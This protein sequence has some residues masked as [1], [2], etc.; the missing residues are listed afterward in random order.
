MLKR[1]TIAFVVVNA[2]A[3]LSR[4]HWDKRKLFGGS[5][6]DEPSGERPQ[7]TFYEVLPYQYGLLRSYIEQFSSRSEAYYFLPPCFRSQSVEN[8]AQ[9]CACADLV[10]YST[11]IWNEQFNLAVARRVKELNPRVVNCFGGPQ[12]PA[13]GE[14]FLRRHTWVDIACFGEGE[15]AFLQVAENLD[16][17]DWSN[18]QGI[19]WL[20]G[21]SSYHQNAAVFLSSP[22]LQ[23]C[24]SPYETGFFDEV[25]AKYPDINWLMLLET[26]RGCPFSCAYCG[27]VSSHI[28]RKV[29]CFSLKRAQAD[30]SWAGEKGIKQILVC[31]SN[32]GMLPR[33]KDI[34][35]YAVHVAGR[36]GAFNAISVQ[37]T[38]AMSERVYAIH[39]KLVAYHLSGGATVGVQS[40]S[41]KVLELCQRRFVPHDELQEILKRF[42]LEGVDTYCDVILGL[43]GET[44]DSFVSGIAELIDCGQY[45]NMFVYCFSPLVNTVMGTADF[46][47]SHSLRTI[48][49]EIS[50]THTP[51]SEKPAMTEYADIV[52]E[53]ATLPTDDWQRAK[54][55][56]WFTHLLF[57]NRV[58]QVPLLIGMKCLRLGIR[59]AMESFLNADPA[60]YPVIAGLADFFLDRARAISQEGVPETLPVESCR[61]ACWPLDQIALIR[62]VRD[63]QL[64]AFYQEASELLT[65]LLPRK[66][67]EQ[68][69]RLLEQCVSLNRALLRVPFVQGNI[70]FETDFN[71]KALYRGFL[72]GESPRL[73]IEPQIYEIIRTRPEWN[74]WDG[75]YD[76]LMFCHNQ[77]KYYLYGL[78]EIHA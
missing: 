53:T 3:N 21:D 65:G 63:G 74:T 32:F 1:K 17:R 7:D 16:N 11:Y 29:R 28:K 37:S 45:N 14:A 76:H 72:K 66:T 31:D 43:P 40:R 15:Q 46:Q 68:N 67:S 44:Y 49:Q 36:T 4:L 12:V 18:C 5:I 57:F 34:I 52:V 48:R 75:W 69:R 62:L 64:D 41:P 54:A 61:D 9:T 19:S 56:L 47:R 24:R 8:T 42:A 73:C 20:D 39:K 60:V 26:N 78:R 30:L 10:G 50:G 25:M 13:D 55:F 59:E 38:C 70:L 51:T 27:W 22:D 33:D 6:A 2:T 58:M 77:R 35:D 71:L 23:Q